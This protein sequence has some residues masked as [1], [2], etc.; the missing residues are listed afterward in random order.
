MKIKTI[1]GIILIILGLA[2]T[3]YIIS[4]PPSPDNKYGVGQ[5]LGILFVCVPL[6]I[7]G[8]LALFSSLGANISFVGGA[9]LAFSFLTQSIFREATPSALIIGAVLISYLLFIV[10]VIYGLGELIGKLKNK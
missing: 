10:G 4:I 1:I 8:V 5:D 2:L 9:I 3:I 6:Y 7:M